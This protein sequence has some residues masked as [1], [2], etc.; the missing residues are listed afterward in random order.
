MAAGR[1]PT[2]FVLSYVDDE[3][4]LYGTALWAAGFFVTAFVDPLRALEQA[5]LHPPDAF[6]ARLMQ[7]GQPIDSIELTRRLRS[8]TRTHRVGIVILTSH[9][10]PASRT[11]ALAAGCDEYLLLP[12]LPCD[13]VDAVKRLTTR[14]GPVPVRSTA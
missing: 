10:D 13:V 3:R 14:S 7:P 5:F 2:V 1:A 11:A 4:E 6:L 9:V 8:D 12:A